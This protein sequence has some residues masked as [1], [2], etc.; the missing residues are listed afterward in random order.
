MVG[1][2]KYNEL[3]KSTNKIIDSVDP[4]SHIKISYDMK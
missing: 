3:L 2:N 4:L 1:E